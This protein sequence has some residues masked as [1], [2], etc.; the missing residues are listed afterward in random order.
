MVKHIDDQYLYDLV[1]KTNEAF[2]ELVYKDDWLKNIFKIV[3]QKIITTQQ[4]D[5]IVG[6]LG[7]P[8]RYCG[9]SPKDAHPHIFVNEDIWDLREKY[10]KMAFEEVNVPADIREK[11][12]AIDQ[13]FK[14]IILKSDVS[15][16]SKRYMTDTIIY[17]PKKNAA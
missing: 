15:E 13:A 12:L 8:K 3:D 10:L 2:Y 14:S 6:A 4:T 1:F 9:R 5:F 17:Y 11:W 16:C 7:G